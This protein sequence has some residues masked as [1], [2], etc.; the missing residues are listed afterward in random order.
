MSDLPVL[1]STHEPFVLFSPPVQLWRGSD[2]A[3][4]VGTWHPAR[5]NPLHKARSCHPRGN[6]HA[7][8]RAAMLGAKPSCKPQSCHPWGIT[9]LQAPELLSLG[10]NTHTRPR[11]A[12]LGGK[13]SCK[14]QSCHPWGITLLQAPELLSLGGNPHT[15]PRA[16]IPGARGWAKANKSCPGSLVSQGI[17]W[18]LCISA[19]VFP[20]LPGASVHCLLLYDVGVLQPESSRIKPHLF[21]VAE[22]CEIQFRLWHKGGKR[23]I[24]YS[25]FI[26]F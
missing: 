22:L 23:L 18:L 14:T 7:S 19:A 16:A 26:L 12:M 4:L 24:G 20:V 1:I 25:N 11:A 6:P 2:R 21:S 5:V 13:P 3:A 9:L 15:R 10:G 8:P 17:T